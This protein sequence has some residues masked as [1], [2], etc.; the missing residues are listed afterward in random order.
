MLNEEELIE[1]IKYMCEQMKDKPEY[2]KEALGK[3]SFIELQDASITRL[4]QIRKLTQIYFGEYSFLVKDEITKKLA[5]LDKKIGARRAI[6]FSGIN[7]DLDIMKND[8]YQKDDKNKMIPSKT[9]MLQRIREAFDSIENLKKRGYIKGEFQFDFS[10]LEIGTPDEKSISLLE[11]KLEL[12]KKAQS[13]DRSLQKYMMKKPKCL[14]GD[15]A[16]ERQIKET[17]KRLK[18]I[19]G[20]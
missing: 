17:Q 4:Y 5:K 16:Y 11:E 3:R 20:K 15:F 13:L 14:M 6:P 10:D 18:D 9:L 7:H 12:L 1:E 2:V 19:L 8:I